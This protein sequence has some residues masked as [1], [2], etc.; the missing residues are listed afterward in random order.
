MPYHV[1]PPKDYRDCLTSAPMEQNSGIALSIEVSGE[2]V[3]GYRM[4]LISW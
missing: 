4:A 2:F 3:F 1:T